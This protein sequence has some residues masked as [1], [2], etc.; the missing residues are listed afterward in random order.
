MQ[1]TQQEFLKFLCYQ[2]QDMVGQQFIG[3]MEVVAVYKNNILIP[4]DSQDIRTIK[5]IEENI[6]EKHQKNLILAYEVD[7]LITLVWN[8]DTFEQKF[9]SGSW[10]DVYPIGESEKN[11]NISPDSWTINSFVYKNG[12][13]TKDLQSLNHPAINMLLYP[14]Q[15]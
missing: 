13:S 6:D 12:K 8:D 9:N 3:V 5:F 1:F 15:N 10:I 11:E 14:N 4:F 2:T 7:G